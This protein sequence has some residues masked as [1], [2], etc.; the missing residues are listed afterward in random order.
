MLSWKSLEIPEVLL[1][2]PQR[3]SDDRG[4][5]SETYNAKLWREAGVPA[6][7]VQDNHSL[8][9]SKGVVRGLHFQ[10]APHA[11]NKLV[12]VARGAIFD[13]AVD[14]RHGSPT[15]GRHVSAILSADNWCQLWI[16]EGFAHGFCTLEP[17]TEVLYKTTGNYS[18][19]ATRG[20]AWNDSDLGIAWPVSIDEAVLSE[21]DRTWPRFGELPEMFRYR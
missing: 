8:S 9:A 16:P 3:H 12:R 5:F 13:V 10:I 7:F 19:E 18:A 15:F 4:F 1:I 14:I 20:I 6:T 11:Q 21:A 2:T 17:D